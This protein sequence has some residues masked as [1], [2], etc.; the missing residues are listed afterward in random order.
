LAAAGAVV[1]ILSAGPSVAAALPVGASPPADASLPGA[2]PPAETSVPADASPAGVDSPPAGTQPPAKASPPAGGSQPA[3]APPVMAPGSLPQPDDSTLVTPGKRIAGDGVG[4]RLIDIATPFTIGRR[5]IEILFTHRF[6]QPVNQGAN[7][8]NL[9][10]LDSGADVGIG[11]TYGLLRRL[12]LSVYRSQFQED[13]ELAGKLQ[14]LDQSPR[15]PLSAAVRAGDRGPAPAFRP[16]AARPRSGARLER[17]P[18]A[19]LGACH[20]AVAQRLERAGR[21][22]AAAARQVAAGR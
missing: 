14:L 11:F 13:F 22:D 8:H 15:V 10:G 17:L 21:A 9:W 3:T 18:L 2:P 19:F 12:D 16:G 1:M 4:S 20:A 7:A 5:R 6:D